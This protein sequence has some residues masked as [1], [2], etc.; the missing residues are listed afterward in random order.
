[1]MK[2]LSVDK[3]READD[4]TIKNEP[5]ESIDLMERAA[6]ACFSWLIAHIHAAKRFLV[7]CGNGNN[8]GDGLVLAR[9]LKQEGFSVLVFMPSQHEQLS[10]DC[11]T[12]AARWL[13]LP[14]A[15]IIQI[16]SNTKLPEILPSDIVVDALFGSGLKRPAEG[17][18]ATLI[19]HINQHQALV[20]SID[21][22][23]G[24]FCDQSN[25]DKFA[26]VVKADYT[27]SFSPPKF[28]FLF[29]ENESFVGDWQLL[30][31]GL[32][33]TFLEKVEVNN[34]YVDRAFVKNILRKRN[35][36]AHKGDFGHALLICGSSGKIG[37]A[38]L[39]ARACLRSGPGLVSIRVPGFGASILQAGVPE[40]MLCIDPDLNIFTEVPDLQQYSSIAIGPGLG[41]HQAT[42]K[43]LKL[44]IQTV[45]T[46][47]IIDA[48]AINILAE[49]KTWISFLP[50]ACIFTPHVKEFERL[51]GKSRND[52]ER[53]KIQ[54]DFSFRYKA[55][56]VLKGAYTAIT[57][58]E[59]NCFFNS[60]GNPGMATGGSGDVLTGIIA[61]ILA[62]G[63]SSLEACLLGVYLHGLAGDLAVS[64]S[65]YEALIANDITE[66]LGKAFQSLYGKF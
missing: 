4:Y 32:M 54:R 25:R 14:D 65:G 5:I 62:Q 15:G 46:P 20:I 17:F 8:G 27:L 58:P 42:A 38:V 28:S 47:L 34:Y 55:Y 49:N 35:K 22:P 66:N 41:Q 51:A 10:A 16:S 1:M 61:G 57:T 39:A 6:T 36:F 60:T 9:L 7:F 18:F 31:I 56:V 29:P 30:D 11:K 24:L 44:L 26:P 12:N 59:G 13:K 21:V 45:Q 50:K 63:Y 40:A 64:V 43:A 3:I 23:S 2:I 19:E 48:D 33:Q 37:A 53:N 52:F